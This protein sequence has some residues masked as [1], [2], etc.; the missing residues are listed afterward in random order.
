MHQCTYKYSIF[1]EDYKISEGKIFGTY[2]NR[3]FLEISF[4]THII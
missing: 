1:T 4:K 3:N 2:D